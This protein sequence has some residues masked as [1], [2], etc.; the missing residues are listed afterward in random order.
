[1]AQLA[2]QRK[3]LVASLMKDGIYGAAVEVLVKHGADG[4][5]MDR[6]AETAGVAKGSLYNYFRNK[7]EMIEFIHEKTI[8]PARLVVQQM[9][10]RSLSAPRKLEAILRTWFEHFTTNRGVFD[11]LFNDPRTREVVEA[12][13]K[14]CRRDGIEDLTAIFQQGI[15]EGSFRPMEPSR[16]AEMFLGAVILT[17]EQQTMLNEQRPVDDSVD[18][19][20]DLFLKG[21]EPRS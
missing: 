16:V 21:L 18:S 6:V 4:L 11:F 20:L 5:T 9:L 3:E 2:Q 14:S 19:L 1:M 7:R 17:V 8:E 13:K 12:R 10:A 15:A